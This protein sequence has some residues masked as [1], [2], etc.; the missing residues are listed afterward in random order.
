MQTLTIRS[1]SRVVVMTLLACAM[2]AVALLLLG[3]T[4]AHA[5]GGVG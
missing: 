5:R 4:A 2:A 1:A 3:A